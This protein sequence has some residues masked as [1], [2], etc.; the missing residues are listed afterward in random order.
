MPCDLIIVAKK[1]A[2]RNGDIIAWNLKDIDLKTR[3][4]KDRIDE[5]GVYIWHSGTGE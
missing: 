4:V 2:K 1:Y 5:I 3:I